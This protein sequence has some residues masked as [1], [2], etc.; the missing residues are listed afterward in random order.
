MGAGLILYLIISY[1]PFYLFII[2]SMKQPKEHACIYFF[3][4]LVGNMKAHLYFLMNGNMSFFFFF[5][6]RTTLY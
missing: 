2:F 5:K 6:A 4:L 3:F 1:F